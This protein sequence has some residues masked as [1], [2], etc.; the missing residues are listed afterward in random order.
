MTHRSVLTQLLTAIFA[1]SLF[2]GCGKSSDQNAGAKPSTTEK[3][4]SATSS[5]PGN[6]KTAEK[7]PRMD[8]K[9]AIVHSLSLLDKKDLVGF[10]N[11]Y[12]PPEALERIKKNSTIE[13]FAKGLSAKRKE[14][15]HKSLTEAKGIAPVYNKARDRATI[16]LKAPAQPL[17]FIKVGDYWY[18]R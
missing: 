14:M 3:T 11:T 8:V 15:F 9:T 13:K 1:V 7:D 16:K 4:D 6:K 10:I 17:S 18:I 2:A 12:M 5:A